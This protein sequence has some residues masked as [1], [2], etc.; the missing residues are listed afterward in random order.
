MWSVW[1]ENV[2]TPL[3]PQEIWATFFQELQVCHRLPW[4]LS[5]KESAYQC[6]GLG[7]DLWVEKIP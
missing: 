6:Q 4:W 2:E 5:G 3:L 7:F 1:E